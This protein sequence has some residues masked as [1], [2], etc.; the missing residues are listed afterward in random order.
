MKIDI[1]E[2]TDQE[3]EDLLKGLKLFEKTLEEKKKDQKF[4]DFVEKYKGYSLAYMD[5][6]EEGG[7]NLH[8]IPTIDYNKKAIKFIGW[9]S[10]YTEEELFEFIQRQKP[11]CNYFI[12]HNSNREEVKRYLENHAKRKEDVIFKY[13]EEFK[14]LCKKRN[15]KLISLNEILRNNLAK[16]NEERCIII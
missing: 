11:N 13:S 10:F 2:L 16:A 14:Q 3:K 4:L 12:I 15:E 8:Q 1:S 5:E 9:K 6:T 7:G